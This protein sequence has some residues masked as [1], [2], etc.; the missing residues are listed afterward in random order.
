VNRS[1]NSSEHPAFRRG[2]ADYQIPL[3]SRAISACAT[4]GGITQA[5]MRARASEERDRGFADSPLE[6]AVTSEPVSEP[7]FPGYWEK[8]RE[9]CLLRPSQAGNEGKFTSNNNTLERD[10]LRNRTGKL[11][12]LSRELKPAITEL[13]A[14]IREARR[15]APFLS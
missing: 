5:P 8:Y 7:Q 12:L 1:E 15:Y 10:S 2:A 11:I 4:S 14:R 6:E 3:R 9:M 13:L